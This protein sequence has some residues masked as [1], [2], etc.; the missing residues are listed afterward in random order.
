MK[1]NYDGVYISIQ[2]GKGDLPGV[3][4]VFGIY[5]GR[6]SV[7]KCFPCTTRGIGMVPTSFFIRTTDWISK[8][9]QKSTVL[10]TLEKIQNLKT[11]KKSIIIEFVP[12]KIQ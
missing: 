3:L 4:G 11:R 7:S 2:A 12:K 9:F 8:D 6:N 10:L 5:K 1:R